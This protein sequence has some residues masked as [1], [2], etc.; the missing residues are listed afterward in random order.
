M[1][2]NKVP[3]PLVS[4]LFALA[5]WAATP[6]LPVINMPYRAKG[7]LI[8]VLVL[9]GVKAA[10]G[11]VLAFREARTTVNPL[12]P[13]RASSLVITGIYRFSRNPMYLGMA[14]FLTAWM[15][16]LGSPLLLLAVIG[17]VL[18][19]NMFQIG[20]EERAMQRLFGAEFESYK[21]QVR[22][23]I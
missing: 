6:Y 5:M 20:P 4:G 14:L 9:L 2:Q 23:W 18:Y 1:L 10:L 16:Y 17:F 3:P 22:R 19:M 21:K 11:G 15:I 7:L 13:E 8:L 12:K